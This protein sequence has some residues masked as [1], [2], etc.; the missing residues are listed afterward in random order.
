[1]NQSWR[2][3]YFSLKRNHKFKSINYLIHVLFKNTASMPVRAIDWW[4]KEPALKTWQ[5]LSK[6]ICIVKIFLW[7]F[8]G[9]LCGSSSIVVEKWLHICYH[10]YT[11]Y[12]YIWVKYEYFKSLWKH[13]LRICSILFGILIT[14]WCWCFINSLFW[15]V[16]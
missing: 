3:V 7:V 6:C 15:G 11:E 12:F 13:V 1:M 8:W 10:E 14:I 9:G 2:S 16:L 5:L 4:E